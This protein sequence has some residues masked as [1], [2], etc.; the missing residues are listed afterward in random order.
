MNF[1]LFTKTYTPTMMSLISL[2]STKLENDIKEDI[3]SENHHVVIN[4]KDKIDQ[5]AE[6]KMLLAAYEACPYCFQPD[7]TSDHK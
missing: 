4:A 6:C 5:L 7:C 1:E 3:L 2:L